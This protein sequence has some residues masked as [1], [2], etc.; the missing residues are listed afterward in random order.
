MIELQSI[1][2]SFFIH[3]LFFIRSIVFLRLLFSLFGGAVD[4]SGSMSNKKKL[5]S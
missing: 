5:L 3:N 2:S 4:K 1:F